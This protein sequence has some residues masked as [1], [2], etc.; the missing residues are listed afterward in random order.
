MK[1]AAAKK[2]DLQL[3]KW[4]KT[5]PYSGFDLTIECFFQNYMKPVKNVHSKQYLNLG[6][7]RTIA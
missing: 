6:V 7:E 3:N 1:L 5:K 2:P 4:K